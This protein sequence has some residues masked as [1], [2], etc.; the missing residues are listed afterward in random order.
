MPRTRRPGSSPAVSAPA[1]RLHDRRGTDRERSGGAPARCCTG[2]K[3][4]STNGDTQHADANAQ[5]VSLAR[6]APG[7]LIG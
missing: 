5:H 1:T 7:S 2:R 6:L 4:V 3:R